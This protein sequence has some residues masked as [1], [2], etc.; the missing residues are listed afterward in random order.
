MILTLASPVL[1]FQQ[2]MAKSESHVQQRLTPT[3]DGPLLEFQLG[4][5]HYWN[6]NLRRPIIGISTWYGPLL[7]FQ[8][9]MAHVGITWRETCIA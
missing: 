9:G 7:E 5:A 3:W 4:M 1:E 2:C 8:L 6:F